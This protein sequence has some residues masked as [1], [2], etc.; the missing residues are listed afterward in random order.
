MM[1]RGG[2][3]VK[4]MVPGDTRGAIEGSIVFID[5]AVDTSTG[6][7]LVKALFQ[8]AD[9]RITPG[10]FVDVTLPVANIDNALVLPASAVQAGPRGEYVYVVKADQT[11]EMRNVK[12][13]FT[14]ADRVA[15]AS[16]VQPGETV[17]IDGQFRLVPGARVKPV[18]EAEG[19]TGQ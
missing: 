15:L 5:N 3:K 2:S 17:V 11:V 8:N 16:G 4:A 7:I 1:S 10:Q 6:T 12:S 18:T 14:L 9:N 19:K 13:E